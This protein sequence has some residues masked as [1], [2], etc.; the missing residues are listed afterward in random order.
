MVASGMND[1]CNKNKSKY[2]NKFLKE[3]ETSQIEKLARDKSRK[4]KRRNKLLGKC[5]KSSIINAR[6]IFHQRN[7]LKKFFLITISG[8]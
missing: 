1:L 2:K 7:W 6:L 4:F 5:S 3:K 8:T